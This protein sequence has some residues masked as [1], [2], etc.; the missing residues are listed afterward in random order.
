MKLFPRGS[1]VVQPQYG[2]GTV[3]ASDE[4]Y[5]VIDFDLHGTR[6]FVTDMVALSASEVPAPAKPAKTRRRKGG[7]VQA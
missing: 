5:T 6:R 1:R 2:A 4:R 7:A 3:T